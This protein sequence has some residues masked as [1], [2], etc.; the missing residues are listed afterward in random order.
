MGNALYSKVHV[1]KENSQRAKSEDFDAEVAELLREER[2]LEEVVF[3]IVGNILGTLI[4]TFKAAFLPFLDDLS[5][6]LMPMRGKDKTA[7]ERI[8][9]INIFLNLVVHCG[10]ASL[11]YYIIYL[12]FILESSNDENPDVRQIAFC[13]LELCAEY[14]GY[15]FKPYIGE[16]LSRINVVIMHFNALEPESLEAYDAAVLAL[17]LV[18]TIAYIKLPTAFFVPFVFRKDGGEV[19]EVKKKVDKEFPF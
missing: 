8:K 9:C 11:R 15:N 17:G 3:G 10:R 4:M 14:G 19:G 18:K 7:K 6:Y 1:E 12:P 2:E 16:A 13:G 5:S